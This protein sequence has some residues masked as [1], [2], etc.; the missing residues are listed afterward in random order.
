MRV[1][2]RLFLAIGLLPGLG[3]AQ[4]RMAPLARYLMPVAAEV[5]LARSAAPASVSLDARVLVL[6]PAG[7]VEAAHGGNG[8]TCL[9][10]RSWAMP[11]ANPDFWDAALRSP[12]CFNPAATASV[13]PQL[14]FRT[15]RAL[16]GDSAAAIRRALVAARARHAL[17]PP[18]PGAMCFMMSKQAHLRGRDPLWHPHLMFFAPAA[19]AP[20]WG[21]NRAGSPLGADAYPESG[22]TFLVEP[23]A[24]WSDGPRDGAPAPNPPDPAAPGSAPYPAMAP[25]DRYLQPSA[26]DEAALARSAAPPS[27]SA[28]ARV[29]V[30]GRGGYTQAARGGNGFVCVVERGWGAA[31]NDPEFWNPHIRAPI[32]FNAA[33]A[34]TVLPLYLMKTKSVLAGQS[35]SA[36]AA[37]IAALRR[38]RTLPRPA[39]W[40]MGYMLSKRQYV[41]D[42]AGSWHPHLMFFLP[43]RV[44]AAWGANLDRSPVLAGD[45]A[46]AGLTTMMVLASAWSD[47][48]PAR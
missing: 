38:A 44:D 48:S 8:F 6:A 3:A 34:A 26:A 20:L 28:G 35:Q 33:A 9:V 17:P 42:G 39:P 19:A 1:R 16:A 18:A 23:V 31:T 46:D 11:A 12:I 29:L 2:I 21:A 24:T 41:H 47:G 30:L 27:I 45:D 5:A 14:L 43:G 4:A 37:T 15:E 32:C 7:Y 40:A 22:L 36:I 13:L 10:K 25:L